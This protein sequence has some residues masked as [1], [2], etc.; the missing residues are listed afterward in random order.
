MP[1]TVWPGLLAL[2]CAG[3]SGAM[4]VAAFHHFAHSTWGNATAAVLLGIFA[5]VLYGLSRMEEDVE[6]IDRETKDLEQK[7]ADLDRR[8][9]RTIAAKDA[10]A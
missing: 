8:R 9:A 3:G 2:I 6:S 4:I 10:G 5:L 7:L 1:H